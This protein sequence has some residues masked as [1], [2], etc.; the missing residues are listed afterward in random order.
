MEPN[1]LDNQIKEKLDRRTIQPSAQ[2]WD[3]LEG[4]LN[5]AEK[6][7]RSYSWVHI[8][9]S[10]VGFFLIATVFFSQ[11]EAL[12]D[13]DKTNP[14][15][16]NPILLEK[17]QVSIDEINKKNRPSKKDAMQSVSAVVI[18]SQ[19]QFSK[20]YNKAAMKQEVLI[21]KKENIENQVV[22]NAKSIINQKNEQI[23]NSE[24]RNASNRDA[25]EQ[26]LLLEQSAKK[27]IAS[28]ISSIKVNANSLLAQVDN[29]LQ[30]S[31]REKVISKVSKN[32]QTVKVALVNRNFE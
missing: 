21:I 28:R 6:P 27:V 10:F 2:A 11:S 25:D 24:I 9:A 29:E 20:G 3:R 32:Y 14:I 17:D 15:I 18:V 30:L 5:A 26:L 31:F 1:K 13:P 4:V 12:I 19:K 7:K 22:Q 23:A 8:A 16:Q